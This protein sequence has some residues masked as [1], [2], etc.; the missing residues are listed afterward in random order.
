MLVLGLDFEATGKDP[1]TSR[2]TEIGAILFDTQS[3]CFLKIYNQLVFDPDTYPPQTEEVVQITGITDEMLKGHGV[4][5]V[6]AL[7]PLTELLCE[8]KYVV[9]HNGKFY[10]KP[11]FESECKRLGIGIS[12]IAL[13]WIDTQT[14]VP[15]PKGM[16]SRKLDHLVSDHEIPWSRRLSHRAIFDVAKMLLVLAHYNFE[17]ISALSQ[18]KTVTLQALTTVPWRDRGVSNSCAKGLGFR[19]QEAGGKVYKNAWVKAVKESQVD[20]EILAAKKLGISVCLV[21]E[22]KEDHEVTST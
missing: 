17:E 18:E 14:D 15:Y 13:P 21:P 11:L 2:I 5:P 10:D 9:A 20:L 19:W 4:D 7:I 16:T 3:R 8:S 22:R 6:A 1:L 12:Q